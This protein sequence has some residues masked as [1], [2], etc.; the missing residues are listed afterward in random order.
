LAQTRQDDDTS[1]TILEEYEKFAKTELIQCLPAKI[2]GCIYEGH[3][4]AYI[5]ANPSNV[6][7]YATFSKFWGILG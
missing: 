4:F 1:I 2:K 5:Q 7:D 6:E 3:Y